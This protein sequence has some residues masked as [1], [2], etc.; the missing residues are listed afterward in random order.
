MSDIS[1]PPLPP[2]PPPPTLPLPGRGIPWDDRER[3]GLAT[4]LVETIK[5]ILLEPVAFFRAMPVSGGL[6]SPL[7]FGIVVGY[8]GLAV[9]AT[10][11]FVFNSVAGRMLGGFGRSG[12]FQRISDMIGSGVGLVLTLLL[13]PVF[14]LVGLFLGAGITH[15][16]L[17][18]L[19]GAKRGFE[20]TFRVACFAQAP[21]IFTIVPFCGGLVHVVYQ[22]VLAIIGISEAHQVSRWTAA[23]AVLLPFVIIC[24]CCG[25]GMGALFGGIAS[26]AGYPR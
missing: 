13:G 11:E 17:M 25:L 10:Y 20:A 23:A 12:E 26:I 22:I 18:L 14:L 6:A 16:C 21:S 1:P 19:G 2:E 4:A 8:F 9:S 7:A 3:L 5:Q 15:L 24:C